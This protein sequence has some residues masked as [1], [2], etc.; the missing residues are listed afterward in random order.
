MKIFDMPKL[1]SPFVRKEVNG[2]Y[3]VTPEIAEGYEW[4]FND[5]SVL[6]TEKLHGTNVSIV[7]QDGVI[8]QVYNT[9]ERIPLFNKGKWHIIEGIMESYRRGYTDFLG[10]GQHFGELIGERVHGNPH[11]IEGHLWIPFKTYAQEHLAYKSWGKYPKT[12]E[13][14]SSWFQNDIFSLFARMKHNKVVKPEGV[15]FVHPDGRMAKLR[16][17]MFDWWVSVRHKKAEK[18]G[19]DGS[20]LQRMR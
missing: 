13:A 18:G 12:F 11:E 4:V 16:L 3:I 19:D 17:D 10:D 14:I 2:E 8:S 9:T 5:D 6:A 20:E 15:V 1:E 7:I